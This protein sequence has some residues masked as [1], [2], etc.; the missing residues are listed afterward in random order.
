[1]KKM[2]A[3]VMTLCLILSIGLTTANAE[4]IYLKQYHIPTAKVQTIPL[5]EAYAYKTQN[6]GY[7]YVRQYLWSD[8]DGYYGSYNFDNYF[9]A[10]NAAGT[11]VGGRWCRPSYAYY[12]QSSSIKKYTRWTAAARGNTDYADVGYSYIMFSGYVDSN[13]GPN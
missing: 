2:L 7:L 10:V 3:F 12:L 5:T 9:Q 1:M 4:V 13:A 6:P 11:R 8:V